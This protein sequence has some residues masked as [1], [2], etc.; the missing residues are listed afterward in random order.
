MVRTPEQ[1][2]KSFDISGLSAAAHS[3]TIQ[4]FGSGVVDLLDVYGKN[5]AVRSGVTVSRMGKW[6]G[7][8]RL[9]FFNFFLGGS[10]LLL[11]ISILIC[12]S[13]S[14]KQT[15]SGLS[16][17]TTQ[18]KNG[19]VEIIAK[20]PGSYARYLYLPGVTGSL[21]RSWYSSSVR[22]RCCHA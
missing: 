16:K 22:V 15:I 9:D 6:R 8:Q 2:L 13:S 5:S 3:P 20:F 11:S 18:Y 4:D 19:L 21:C 17:G 1:T 10:N 7:Y 12:C 14:L